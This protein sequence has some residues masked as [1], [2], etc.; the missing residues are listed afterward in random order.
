MVAAGK[1]PG[2]PG[3]AR[4]VG[5]ALDD[6]WKLAVASTSSEASVRAVLE[7]VVGTDRAARFEVLAG[8]IVPAKKPAPDIYL[9]AVERLAV[10]PAR[11]SWWRTRATGCS[12]RSAAGLPCVVTVSSYTVDEDFAEAV[13]VVS[14]LGEPDGPR[15]EVLAGRDIRLADPWVQLQDLRACLAASSV[16]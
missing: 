13:L 11:R 16:S 14:S 1:L 6:G 5:E 4:I 3:V 10:D 7:H 8:D 9:L 15:T 12:R 2:R